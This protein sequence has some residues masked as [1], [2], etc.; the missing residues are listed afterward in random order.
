MYLSVHD[1]VRVLPADPSPAF[2]FS[3][4]VALSR[5]G[6]GQALYCAAVL[7]LTLSHHGQTPDIT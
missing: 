5:K 1:R 3:R 2:L 7:A 6:R 4:R